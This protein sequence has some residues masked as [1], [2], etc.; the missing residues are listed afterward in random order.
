LPN[1]INRNIK[2]LLTIGALDAALVFLKKAR[3]LT[4]DITFHIHIWNKLVKGDAMSKAQS[5][6]FSF[7]EK[8][9]KAMISEDCRWF[10]LSKGE[11]L[12]DCRSHRIFGVGRSG[13]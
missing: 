5:R 12:R 9:M 1:G 8:Y 6:R 11:T 3:F 10:S 4:R 2:K 7:F 13:A